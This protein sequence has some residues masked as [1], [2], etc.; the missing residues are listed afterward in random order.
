MS[1]PSDPRPELVDIGVNLTSASFAAD[2][3]AVVANAHASGVS[4]LVLI[5]SDIEDSEAAI[6]LCGRFDN[7]VATAGI[8][9]HHASSFTS[10]SI[11]QL[12]E[13]TRGHPAHLRALGEMGLDFNRNYSTPEQQLEAFAAQLALAAE[14]N[15][16]VY[17]H[18]RDAHAA[19]LELVSEYRDR[20]PR[21]VAHCFTGTSTELHD[22]LDLDL[23]I[24]ITGWICDERRGLPLRDT[25]RD[26]PLQRLML[27]TDAPYLL[28]R[29]IV[30]KP[31]SRRNEPAHLY[32]VLQT[33]AACMGLEP[34][35]VAT[36]TT[37]TA[38]RFFALD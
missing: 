21:A 12:R 14:L 31:K 6:S 20:L 26:I 3:A 34:A 22:Y 18:Q 15:L 10:Q 38:K 28:P 29:N 17:L 9:P 8:H 36:A 19:F 25:V 23:H 2:T 7:C 33:L 30:P 37:A 35:A 11:S 16:P 32:Y 1:P 24:G 13:L 4:H 27:E 5:G